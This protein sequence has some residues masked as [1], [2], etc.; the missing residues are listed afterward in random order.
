MV[1]QVD[2][3]PKWAHN[4]SKRWCTADSRGYS[5]TR[6]LIGFPAMFLERATRIELAFSA[7][8][9]GNYSCHQREEFL[10]ADEIFGTRKE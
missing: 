10:I 2:T 9:A 7:W 1:C 4:T 3:S 6:L 8:E 5:R